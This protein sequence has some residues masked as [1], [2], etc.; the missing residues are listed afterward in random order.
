MTV[1][2]SFKAVDCRLFA[3]VSLAVDLASKPQSKPNP[4]HV[5]YDNKQ[6]PVPVVNHGQSDV[7]PTAYL[8]GIREHII[9]VKAW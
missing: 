5:R 4:S 2:S 6:M 3:M 8:H 7:Q 9:E 1:T